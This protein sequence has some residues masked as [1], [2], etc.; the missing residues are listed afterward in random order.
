[1][2][3]FVCIVLQGVVENWKKMKNNLENRK[4]ENVNKSS[5]KLPNCF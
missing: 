4:K 5:P 2:N 1:M 3:I